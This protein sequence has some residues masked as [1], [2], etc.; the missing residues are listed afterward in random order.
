MYLCREGGVT[1]T[2]PPPVAS[3]P[4]R[5]PNP[6]HRLINPHLT[7]KPGGTVKANR[8]Q[9]I[10]GSPISVNT[11]RGNSGCGGGI[12][13]SRSKFYPKAVGWGSVGLVR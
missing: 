2:T 4:D 3:R 1:P 6:F 12:G 13:E 11:G 10:P 7:E 5:Q 9:I 8:F